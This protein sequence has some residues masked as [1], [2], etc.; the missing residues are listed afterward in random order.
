[1]KKLIILSFFAMII[2]SINAN[3]KVQVKNNSK[4]KIS[5]APV[6]ICLDKLNNFKGENLIVKLKGKEIPSQMDDLNRD[7]KLDVI[8][9][10]TDFKPGEQ[11][12]IKL[13]KKVAKKYSSGVYTS[14][15]KKN[16][17]G[18]ILQVDSASSDK[19]DMYN[20]LL[21]H[22]VAFETDKIAYRIYFDNKSTIDI[23]GKKKYGFELKDNNWYPTDD[24]L[25]NGFGDDILLVSSWVGNGTVKGWDGSKALHMDK[26]A[27]RTH[28]IIAKGPVRAVVQSELKAWDYEGKK[29]DL[30]V[31]YT[32]YAGHRDVIAEVISSEAINQIATGVQQI[33]GG[34][35]FRSNDLVGSWGSWHPQPDT[36]KY[37]K[38]TVGLGLYLPKSGKQHLDGVNNLIVFPVSKSQRFYFTTIAAKEEGQKIQEA[39]AFF[40][41]L[42]IWK[43]Q[44]DA[45]EVVY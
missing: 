25:A 43:S 17:D 6:E 36:L 10:Q 44:V 42:K 26:F 11:L 19:N 29:I 24:Q 15:I 9:F 7:G 40:E 35:F 13:Q 12:E 14:L 3:Y 31:R 27:K 38:E 21:H 32:I 20:K 34:E 33:G 37:K 41:Y 22:G 1:M 5:D 2:T 39:A 8:S 16:E 4:V 30:I 45:I 23:Y 18:S 28:R